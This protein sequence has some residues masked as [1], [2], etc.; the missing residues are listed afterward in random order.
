MSVKLSMEL[1]QIIEV[2]EPQQYVMLNAWI[3][4][5]WNDQKLYWKKDK[6][7]GIEEIILPK[8]S[9][10]IPDTTLYNS[11]LMNDEDT[12]RVINT[13]ITLL[14]DE[15]NTLVELLYPT[16]Y[17]F[18]CNLDL[19][20]FPFDTQACKMTFGSWIYDMVGIDY[21]P[22]NSTNNAFGITNCIENEGWKILGTK[23]LRKEV[24]YQCCANKYVLLEFVL[25]I[26]RKPLFYIANLVTP[27]AII[28][29]IA[30]IGFFSTSN[31]HAPREEKITLGITTLLSM[32]II[33]FLV[34]DKL[35]STSS[36][37]PLIGWFYTFMLLLISMGTLA[38]SYV[39]SVQKQGIIGKRPSPKVMKWAIRFGRMLRMKMPLL[40]K[41]AYME[42]AAASKLLK[43]RRRKIS[44]R[45]LMSTRDYLT[46]P[47]IST[48]MPPEPPLNGLKLT[49]R[50]KLISES[51]TIEDY[52]DDDRTSNDITAS[53][54]NSSRSEKGNGVGMRKTR[55]ESTPYVY[56]IRDNKNPK[57]GEHSPDR[58]DP[59][60]PKIGSPLQRTMAEIEYDWVAAVVERT[61][62]IIFCILFVLMSLGVNSIGFFYWYFHKLDV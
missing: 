41:Q 44:F 56:T 54:I 55:S 59:D 52:L 49:K 57:L 42:Q 20:Y 29:L 50:Q 16:L 17:K 48:I 53:E 38:S 36:Y 2:N 1:Y 24:K 7:D 60:V 34:S 51:E 13:K 21:Y 62:L 14:P 18:S 15:K 58:D 11:L 4:E 31:M 47:Q 23:V 61:L 28:T 19:R 6:F 3:V 10:W 39:M 12:R 46:S 5:R 27:T 8:D 35:P 26:Q 9:I 32:C 40:M 22:Y 33:I 37:I 43:Q 30:I 25:Y 45:N